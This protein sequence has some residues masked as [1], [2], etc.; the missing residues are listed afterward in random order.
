M[1]DKYIVRDLQV[2]STTIA[3]PSSDERCKVLVNVT[4]ELHVSVMRHM[5]DNEN[6][7]TRYSDICGI[8]TS[9][10]KSDCNLPHLQAFATGIVCKFFN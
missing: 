9:F 6:Q 3:D 8:I 2:R 10:A 4:V 7:S 5:D 1:S